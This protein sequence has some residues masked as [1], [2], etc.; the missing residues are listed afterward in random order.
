MPITES[1]G[2]VHTST[3]SIATLPEAEDIDFKLDEKEIRIDTYRAQGAG[4]QSVNKTD[5]AVRVVHIPTGI[6]VAIQDE[7]A[8]HQNKA[9]AL[10]ILRTRLYD[11]ERMKAME[12]RNKKRTVQI[13]SGGRHERIRTYNFPQDRITDH[14]IGLTL[15]NLDLMMEGELLEEFIQPLK[16]KDRLEQIEE[17]Q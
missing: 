15:H 16:Q 12:Q 17:L 13:G 8:Q 3:M 14:R 10:S 7:R 5:S 11:M 2:R 4:G 6:T 1:G 9:R